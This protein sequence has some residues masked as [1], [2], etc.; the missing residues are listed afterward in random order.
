MTQK[1]MIIAAVVIV[2]AYFLFFYK[3]DEKEIVVAPADPRIKPGT[4]IIDSLLAPG[5]VNDSKYARV[6]VNVPVL[7]K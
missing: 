6:A 4:S 1:Q 2:A 7:A 3:K 5:I